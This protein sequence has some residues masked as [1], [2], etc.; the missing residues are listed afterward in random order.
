MKSILDTW[1]FQYK[2][3]KGQDWSRPSALSNFPFGELSAIQRLTGLTTVAT[4]TDQPLHP[5]LVERLTT[6]NS[7][8][9]PLLA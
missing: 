7:K 4:P 5:I 8:S 9:A 1:Y 6:L 3:K 2:V